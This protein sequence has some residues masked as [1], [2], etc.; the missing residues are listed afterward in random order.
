MTCQVRVAPLNGYGLQKVAPISSVG[1]RLS[2]L[3]EILKMNF[4]EET[5]E[6]I[7]INPVPRRQQTPGSL[8]S[9]DRIR[10]I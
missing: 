1:E 6:K 4:L 9:G 8:S 5:D 3:L 10:R 7:M 2:D